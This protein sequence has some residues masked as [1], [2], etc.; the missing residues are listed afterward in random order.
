MFVQV[1]YMA[2]F[3][4]EEVAELLEEIFLF[5]YELDHGGDGGLAF[6][7]AVICAP[8]DAEEFG[9]LVTVPSVAVAPDS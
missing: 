3:L 4:F 2:S 7:P 6:F 9:R 8:G 5:D 1:A